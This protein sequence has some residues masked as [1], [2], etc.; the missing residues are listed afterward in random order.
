MLRVKRSDALHREI[1][2]ILGTKSG[3]FVSD[4][5]GKCETG[6][7]SGGLVPKVVQKSKTGTKY[8]VSVPVFMDVIPR[9]AMVAG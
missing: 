2:W 4:V 6:T 1:C 9:R 5:V 8:C 7:E 3:V